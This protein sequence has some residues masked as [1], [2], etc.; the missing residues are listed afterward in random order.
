M[1]SLPPDVV[2]TLRV[3]GAVDPLTHFRRNHGERWACG[4][5]TG[6]SQLERVASRVTCKGCRRTHAHEVAAAVEVA[7]QAL[8][9]RLEARHRAA[10]AVRALTWECPLC[11]ATGEAGDGGRCYQCAGDGYVGDLGAAGWENARRAPR[12]PGVRRT[13]CHDCAFRPQSQEDEDGVSLPD[14]NTPF[15]CHQGT[16]NVRGRY[17]PLLWGGGLPIGSTVC[18]G[19][20]DQVICG[21]PKQLA[22]AVYPQVEAG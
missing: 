5:G 15:F 10:M 6:G 2:V 16:P 3:A 18:A 1:S 14:D 21:G 4:Q 8:T 7:E 12:P 19:W 20:W 11:E 17:R 9:I 22:P 13:A